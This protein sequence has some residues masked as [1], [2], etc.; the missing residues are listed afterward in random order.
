MVQAWQSL[1]A[2]RVPIH[3]REVLRDPSTRLT[4]SSFQLC[5]CLVVGRLFDLRAQLC[6]QSSLLPGY[7]LADRLPSLPIRSTVRRLQILARRQGA[8]GRGL[9]LRSRGPRMQIAAKVA[10]S[11]IAETE[12]PYPS[13]SVDPLRPK[14]K[15]RESQFSVQLKPWPGTPERRMGR[16]PRSLTRPLRESGKVWWNP[17][18]RTRMQ[19]P[20]PL[21]A[22][23]GLFLEFGLLHIS[24]PLNNLFPSSR[25]SFSPRTA[26]AAREPRA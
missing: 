10:R 26:R 21:L 4:A 9:Y 2:G 7:P 18:G 22:Q 24:A 1:R 14:Q 25:F 20:T 23:L 6:L 15:H 3:R 17:Q 19:A 13:L 11:A 8:E 12:S 16:G 5:R